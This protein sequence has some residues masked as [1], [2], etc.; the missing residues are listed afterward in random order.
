MVE[1]SGRDMKG[2]PMLGGIPHR[3]APFAKAENAGKPPGPM[4]GT[5]GTGIEPC[6]G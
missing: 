3:A 5:L 4:I 1:L 6:A 2:L